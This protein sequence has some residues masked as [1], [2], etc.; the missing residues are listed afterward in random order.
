MKKNVMMRL[1]CF[2]LVAVLIST[3][4][5][6]GTYAKY[7]TQDAGNDEARVAKWG[8]ELQVFGNLYGDTYT[9]PIVRETTDTGTNIRVQTLDTSKDVVAPGTLNAEGFEL[10]LKGK[11]EVDGIITTEIKAQN[12]FLKDAE[13]G[14]MVPVEST[15]NAAN[16]N[17]FKEVAAGELYTFKDGTYTVATTFE[18][19]K[20]YFTLEDYVNLEHDYY[21]VVYTLTGN[22]ATTGDIAKDTL[23]L[24]KPDAKGAAAAIAAKL[25]ATTIST[26]ANHVTTYTGTSSFDANTDLANEYKL[27]NLV[28][29]W[30]WNFEVN[31]DDGDS[32]NWTDKA[33]TILGNLHAG[34]GMY[35]VTGTKGGTF[36]AVPTTYYC[37]ETQFSIDITVTQV[38]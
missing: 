25:N 30:A 2:L 12:I 17:E 32:A 31:T 29:T 36:T 27:D 1:A 26:D 8:V 24:N 35:V 16:F 15:I 21:P 3:S 22:T 13:Y 20:T 28:L 19:G 11:P 34:S 9:N 33:D 5:I 6:S 10:S 37:L 38:D 14:V 4:A 18:E 23:N 7:T